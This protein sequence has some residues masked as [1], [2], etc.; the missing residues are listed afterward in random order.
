MSCAMTA[1]P[2][3]RTERLLM[4]PWRETDLDDYAAMSAD[5]AVMRYIGQGKI[6]HFTRSVRCAV[7]GVVVNG[8][9]P[10]VAR[11]LQVG[12]DKSRP[13]G[14]R[15]LKRRQRVFRRVP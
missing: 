3:V 6:M 12:L 10:R 1:I 7:H 9:K 14:K 8:H 2:E 4:R 5:P 13:Q 11:K 15:A